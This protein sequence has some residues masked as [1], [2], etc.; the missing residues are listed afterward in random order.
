MP[1]VVDVPE[2]QRYE[3]RVEEGRAGFVTYRRSPGT[4]SVVHTEMAPEFEGRGLGSV[5]ARGVLDAARAD[6]AQV[7]PYCP[8][9]RTWL[10]RHPDYLPLVPADRRAEFDLPA[11]AAAS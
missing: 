1:E 2:A 9:I 7:L 10:E 11:E 6:G 5:L 8:F 4:L 3:V